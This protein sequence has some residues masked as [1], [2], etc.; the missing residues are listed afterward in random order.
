MRLKTLSHRNFSNVTELSEARR[1][2]RPVRLK[3]SRAAKFN[4][5]NQS[6][7]INGFPAVSVA[8]PSRWGNPFVVGQEAK[9]AAEAVAAYRLQLILR[10]V[11]APDL[12]EPLR[13]K[14]LACWC[15]LDAPC[16]ADVLLDFANR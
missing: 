2:V 7:Q 3:L 1:E 15:A 8:R 16:H 10:L 5:Q 14:N 11:Q 6:A 4:L 13:K 9:D 12:L